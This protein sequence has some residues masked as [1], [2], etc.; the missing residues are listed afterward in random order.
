[1]EFTR[2]VG[3]FLPCQRNIAQTTE[4]VKDGIDCVVL[5]PGCEN[6]VKGKVRISLEFIPEEIEEEEIEEVEVQDVKVAQALLPASPLDDL[7]EKLNV[8]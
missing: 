3:T 5:Q 7:R 8:E 1:M 6:W 4:W 2:A